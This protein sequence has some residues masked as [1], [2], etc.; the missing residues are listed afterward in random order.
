M[1]S[2]HGPH[3]AQPP[4]YPLVTDRLFLRPFTRGDVDAVFA[5]RRLDT[6]ARYLFDGPMSYETC[7]EVVVQRTCQIDLVEEGDRIVLAI[8]RQSDG[9]LIGEVSLILRNAPSRQAELGYI[10]H[11]DHHGHGYATEA[12]RALIDLAFARYGLHRVYACCASG[13]IGSYRVMDRLGMRREAHLRENIFVKGAWEE[14]LVYAVLEQEWS[15]RQR[16]NSG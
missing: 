2:Q 4:E 11:P 14:E 5:Y 16:H 12:G 7:T 13:N 6:V 9:Q 10:L 1:T 15:A 8:D 3:L